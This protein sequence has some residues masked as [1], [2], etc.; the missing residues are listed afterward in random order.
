MNSFKTNLSLI[1]LAIFISSCAPN[2]CLDPTTE[3]GQDE[4]F[5]EN[6]N[7]YSDTIPVFF[8]KA[9]I[10]PG[11][12]HPELNPIGTIRT[13]LLTFKD[14]GRTRTPVIPLSKLK[15]QMLSKGWIPPEGQP[16]A[17]LTAFPLLQNFFKDSQAYARSIPD[18]RG[19]F[20]QGNAE[21]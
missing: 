6:G 21:D 3:Y 17:T 12:I 20:F 11:D 1:L 18:T 16:L 19:R 8:I 14:Q 7:P 10:T 13:E 9:A 15:L 4:Y 2:R 5:Q